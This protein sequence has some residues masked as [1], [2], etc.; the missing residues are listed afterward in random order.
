[1]FYLRVISFCGLF[2][3]MGLAWL[4]STH[5]RMINIRVVIVGLLLQFFLALVM[6]RSEPGRTFFSSINHG[7]EI[8]QTFVDVGTTF[9]FGFDRSIAT[10]TMADRFFHSFLFSVVPTII[11]FSSL[12]SVLYYL[13]IM[14]HIVNA[15]ARVM[16]WAMGVSGAES[17]STAANI[18]VGQTEAPLVI[19]PYLNTMTL[20]ELHAVMVG[21]FATIAGGVMAAYVKMGVSAGHLVIASVISAPATLL[22]AKLMVPETEQ[23]E[24]MGRVRVEPPRQGHNVIEAAAI[25]ATDGIKLAI[26]VVGMIL[27]FLALIAMLNWLVGSVGW[28]LHFRDASG[29]STWSLVAA[30]GYLFSPIAFFMGIEANDCLRSGE[31]LGIKTV[32]NEFVAYKQL[33]DWVKPN[34]GVTLSPRSVT[35]M[36]YALCGFANFGSIGIQ[37]AG[38]GGLAPERQ[39]DLARLGL[40]AMIGGA[41]ANC[42]TACIVGVIM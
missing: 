31:L 7:F 22:I 4:M 25:G 36:T 30:F 29:N 9:V 1:M 5:K 10:N 38:I 19:R 14:Q 39:P 2:V 16:Q 18:F 6:L 12:M 23:P 26:N 33:T 3:M 40:R 8:L 24:T 15:M 17:L 27:A 42:M 32:A 28:L 41:L 34:S 20:S 35:L 13:G 37:I 11:F 21:G